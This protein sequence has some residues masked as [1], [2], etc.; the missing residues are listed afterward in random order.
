MRGKL[1]SVSPRNSSP[2]G[3][4]RAG[5]RNNKISSDS[6]SLSLSLSLCL[7]RLTVSYVSYCR[8]FPPLE[9]F[10]SGE[11]VVRRGGERRSGKVSDYNWIA[12]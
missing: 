10:L 12:K 1:S 9:R 6:D 11:I 8:K 3:I 4:G 2:P 5:S 7:F